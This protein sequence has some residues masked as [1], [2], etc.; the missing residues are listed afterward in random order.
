MSLKVEASRLHIL[1]DGW[2]T[3]ARGATFVAAACA[4]PGVRKLVRLFLL[5]SFIGFLSFICLR[6]SVAL[7]Y[8]KTSVFI[9]TVA[10]AV[11]PQLGEGYA[12]YLDV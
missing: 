4:C 1:W 7:V 6:L 10:N 11:R 9:D 8:L 5:R 12:G 2:A 3:A